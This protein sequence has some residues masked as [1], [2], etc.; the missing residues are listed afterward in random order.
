MK[1]LTGELAYRQPRSALQVHEAG[2]SMC[3]ATGMNAS[4]AMGPVP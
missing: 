2:F 1:F 4:V 3:S